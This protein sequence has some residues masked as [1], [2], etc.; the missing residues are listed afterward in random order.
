MRPAREDDLDRINEIYT[1]TIVGSHVSFDLEPWDLEQRRVWW[2]R[3]GADGPHRAP[4]AEI[5]GTVVGIAYSSPY[6]PKKAY[7]SSAETTIV[8][9]PDYLRLGIGRQ[10]LTA[11]LEL[12]RDDGFHRAYAIVAL[13]NDP[14]MGL[15]KSLGS[16]VVGTLEGA[17]YKLGEYWSSTIMERRLD[18][19]QE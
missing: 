18:E 17:G 5:G 9:D 8:L 1:T 7:Q 15:H 10:L 6:R 13:P 3:Y 11:L 4:I 12:L 2:E 19:I 14:S 16:R